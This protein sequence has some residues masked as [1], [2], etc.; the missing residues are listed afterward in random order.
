MPKRALMLLQPLSG[1]PLIEIALNVCQLSSDFML[2]SPV[3][4]C[5][6]KA[7]SAAATR[8]C[9]S[10]PLSRRLKS[11]SS[12]RNSAHRSRNSANV[13]RRPS[14]N[15]IVCSAICNKRHRPIK[16]VHCKAR[17]V[18]PRARLCCRWIAIKMTLF[19]KSSKLCRA[20][21]PLFSRTSKRMAN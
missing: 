20:L 14:R 15:C 2:I 9:H 19:T 3:T 16:S 13:C 18:K 21:V 6:L 7:R 12:D 8:P 11:H 5:C 17:F 4:H 10:I 1:K